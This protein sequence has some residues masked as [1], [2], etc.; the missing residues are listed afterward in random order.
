MYVHLFI[1][2]GEKNLGQCVGGSLITLSFENTM[3]NNKWQH[4]LLA[5]QIKSFKKY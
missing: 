4:S 5:L 3:K 1:N 2:Y